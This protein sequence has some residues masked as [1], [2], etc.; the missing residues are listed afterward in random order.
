MQ[1]EGV[2][3]R[4]AGDCAYVSVQRA[5]GCGRC[6]EAGGCGGDFEVARCEEFVVDNLFGAKLGQRVTLE[7]PAG[8]TLRA[9]ALAYGIPLV[10]TL[11]GAALGAAYGGSELLTALMAL[12]GLVLA[13]VLGYGLRRSRVV[14]GSQVRIVGLLL[15]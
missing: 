11:L 10:L 3:V 15:P 7:V 4:L 12:A 1:A 13:F 5:K 9:A 14:L 2:V 8:A 6:H